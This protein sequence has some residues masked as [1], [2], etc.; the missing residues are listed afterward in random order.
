MKGCGGT[1]FISGGMN[2]LNDIIIKSSK[3]I[4]NKHQI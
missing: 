1:L 4:N 3:V 2:E